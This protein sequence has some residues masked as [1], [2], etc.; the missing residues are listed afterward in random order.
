M[1]EGARAY[2]HGEGSWFEVPVVVVSSWDRCIF[3]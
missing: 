3:L 2:W 1:E